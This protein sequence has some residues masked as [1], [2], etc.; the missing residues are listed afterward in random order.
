M[1]FGLRFLIFFEN[2][3]NLEGARMQIRSIMTRPGSMTLDSSWS[4]FE[5]LKFLKNA[6]VSYI[7]VS[8]NG[9]FEGI[10]S[11]KQIFQHIED[12]KLAKSEM[13]KIPIIDLIKKDVAIWCK[14]DDAIEQVLTS[15]KGRCLDFLPVR[16]MGYVV[17][18]VSKEHL[19]VVSKVLDSTIKR[20]RIDIRSGGRSK[21]KHRRRNLEAGLTVSEDN[22]TVIDKVKYPFTQKIA[23]KASGVLGSKRDQ[24][25]H[26]RVII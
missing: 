10:L 22:S 2:R 24:V 14:P 16:Y 20:S 7:L 8:K 9:L 21:T 4:L 18:I 26:R 13:S 11:K 15:M 6:T 23:L 25:E 5:V 12:Q 17:G 3:P 1:K 19:T